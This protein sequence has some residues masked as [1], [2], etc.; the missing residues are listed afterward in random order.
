MSPANPAAGQNVTFS[1]VVKNQGTGVTPA[2]VVIGVA[3]LVDGTEVTWSDNDSTSLAPGASVTLTA[4]NGTSGVATWPATNG[5][6]TLEAYVNDIGRFS[7]SN[8]SNNTLNESFTVGTSPS[9]TPT[10]TQTSGYSG[11]VWGAN[12]HDDQ[13]TYPPS[14]SITL[15]QMESDIL[16][17]FG[18]AHGMPLYRGIDAD[19]NSNSSV[20]TQV[21]QL[22]AAGIQPIVVSQLYP[23]YSSETAAYN[24]AYSAVQGILQATP[25]LQY[26]EIGNEWT[27]QTT[28]NGD[29][30]TAADWTSNSSYPMFRGVIAGAVAAARATNPNVKVI[31]G[32]TSGWTYLGLPLAL[33]ADLKSYKNPSGVTANLMWDYTNLHWY[34]DADSGNQM[35]LPSNFNGGMNAYTM[36]QATGKPLCIT[37]FGS[38][39]GNS[40][41]GSGNATGYE[42]AAGSNITGLMADF[43]AH[44]STQNG[45][46]CATAY[47]LYQQ[48]QSVD[49]YDYFLYFVQS[50]FSTVLAPQGQ[51]VKSWI[52]SH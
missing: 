19:D 27:L 6:H 37:E 38:S 12:G 40:A 30:S 11:I 33:A 10:P 16:N 4:D 44:Q 31:G 23:G 49:Q 29:G 51:D 42:S 13:G 39:S 50:N 21:T 28:P 18:S 48:I 52:S 1:A 46:A 9:P 43:L 34:N 25:S 8:T 32:A 15:S 26:L 20:N 45:V 22:Q 14:G 41:P 5:S 35:G 2:G 24:G 3:F 36:L 17:V 7:E 47:E